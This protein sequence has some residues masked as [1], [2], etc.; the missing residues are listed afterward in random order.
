MKLVVT[1]LLYLLA[2]LSGGLD[3]AQASVANYSTPSSSV[4]Q[5]AKTLSVSTGSLSNNI[6]PS[7][8]FAGEDLLQQLLLAED[9][10]D[11]SRRLLALTTCL[12]FC[13]IIS[14][15]SSTSGTV[16]ERLPQYR[17]LSFLGTEKYIVQRV[18]R[19]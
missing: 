5:P 19:I 9:D 1:I 16:T 7:S 4:H 18:I 14:I 11:Q 3:E 13:Y 12:L 8:S 15:G 6:L 10:D 2:H 17:H